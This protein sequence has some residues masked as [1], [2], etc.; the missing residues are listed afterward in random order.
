MIYKEQICDPLIHHPNSLALTSMSSF[1][2]TNTWAS[3]VS[4]SQG[5]LMSLLRG[6]PGDLV[7]RSEQGRVNVVK[8]NL[9]T[10]NGVAVMGSYVYV[11]LTGL[12]QVLVME[13]NSAGGGSEGGRVRTSTTVVLPSIPDNVFVVKETGQLVV[14]GM[15]H[16][17][18]L[19]KW[20]RGAGR[21]RGRGMGGGGP[22]KV[23]SGIFTVF[24]NT[25]KDSQFYGHRFVVSSVVL[26]PDSKW[27][28][29]PSI[30]AVHWPSKKMLVGGPLMKGLVECD[31]PTS[32]KEVKN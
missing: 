12:G 19:V 25:K 11:V 5:A 29:V 32:I 1:Y 2:L 3:H 31:W 28:N 9:I 15:L 26:D 20:F 17:S 30:A 14:T 6:H 18:P 10:P 16:A 4:P 21:E 27:L 8:S 13:R 23:P 24:N 22:P 7:Y